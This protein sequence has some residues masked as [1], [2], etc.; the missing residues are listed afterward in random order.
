MP[1]EMM[2][3]HKPNG[4]CIYLGQTGCTIHEDKPLMCQ[5]MDCRVIAKELTYT[6]ARKIKPN[7]IRVWKKGKALIREQKIRGLQGE[8]VSVDEALTLEK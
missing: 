4:D 8:I 1:G 6:Q 7:I 3:D 5:R 2:L